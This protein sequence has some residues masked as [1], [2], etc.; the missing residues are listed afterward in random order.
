MTPRL[1]TLAEDGY[2]K[3]TDF[4]AVPEEGTPVRDGVCLS[5]GATGGA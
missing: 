1:T 4:A 3:S 5:E 2:K